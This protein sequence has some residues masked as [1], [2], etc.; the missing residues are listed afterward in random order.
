MINKY[1]AEGKNDIYKALSNFGDDNEDGHKV[2]YISPPLSLLL[3]L[4]TLPFLLPPQADSFERSNIASV[5]FS[6]VQGCFHD[7]HV[8]TLIYQAISGHSME[9]RIKPIKIENNQ[10]YLLKIRMELDFD[11][12]FELR[13]L[14]KNK[15]KVDFWSLIFTFYF[16]F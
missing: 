2:D 1:Y 15:V 14:S 11:F 5:V 6:D 7:K 4:F 12:D 3:L 16:D 9:G 13:N 10:P 8:Q